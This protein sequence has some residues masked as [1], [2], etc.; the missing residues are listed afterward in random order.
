MREGRVDAELAAG[1]AE[2]VGEGLAG[3]G[4]AVAEGP[5]ER[6]EKIKVRYCT[7]NVLV[8]RNRFFTMEGAYI[9]AR[10]T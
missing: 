2:A 8:I 5:K 9:L 7:I 3:R 1:A 6:K 4:L 10:E